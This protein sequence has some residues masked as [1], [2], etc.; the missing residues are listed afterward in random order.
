MGSAHHKHQFCLPPSSRVQRKLPR[1]LPAVCKITLPHQ[2]T[3]TAAVIC[4]CQL[5]SVCSELLKGITH[6]I[7]QKCL[8][9]LEYNTTV[10][11][12]YAA[13]K[14]RQYEAEEYLQNVLT[15][16]H[17]VPQN[18]AGFSRLDSTSKH[19][20]DKFKGHINPLSTATYDKMFMTTKIK[21]NFPAS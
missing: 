1:D 21:I 17:Q 20:T 15:Y 11:L 5:Q 8:L 6:E 12:Q 7:L 13:K 10:C 18:C 9:L 16:R 3:N 4:G 19:L 2:P 14:P